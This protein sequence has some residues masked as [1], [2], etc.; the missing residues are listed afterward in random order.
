MSHL[1]SFPSF[2]FVSGEDEDDD[3]ITEWV[4]NV[5]E[6]GHSRVLTESDALLSV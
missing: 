1:A 5:S 6:R 2:A 4:G 3:A